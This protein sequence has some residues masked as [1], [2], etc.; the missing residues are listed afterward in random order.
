MTFRYK[1]ETRMIVALQYKFIVLE[2]YCEKKIPTYKYC[3]FN[4]NPN[5]VIK[6]FSCWHSRHSL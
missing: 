5:L 3:S 2:V 4:A 6:I 1:L